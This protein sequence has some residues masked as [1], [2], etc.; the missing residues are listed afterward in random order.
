MEKVAVWGLGKEFS[1]WRTILESEELGANI[2]AWCD[3]DTEKSKVIANRTDPSSLPFLE[4]DII[5]TSCN[6]CS[7]IIKESERIGCRNARVMDFEA[8]VKANLKVHRKAVGNGIHMY[9]YCREIIER[10]DL[11]VSSIME[12]GANYGQDAEFLRLFWG[13]NQDHV[14]TFEANSSISKEIDQRYKFHNYNLAVSDYTGKATLNLVDMS[15]YNSGL[16]SVKNYSYTQNWIRDEVDCICMK[17]FMD[18]HKEI[19]TIDF[20]KVDV[21]GVD[22]EV[23]KGFG[24]YL[25]KVKVIQTEAENLIDY[26]GEHYLFSDIARLLMDFGF[27]LI[28][29]DLAR[30][31]SDSLWIKR[32]LLK[33]G[34]F[35]V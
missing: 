18:M 6:L 30:L 35:Q 7:E 14:F 29:Y 19:D 3:K 25:H 27:E 5:L 9:R 2:I 16:S 21:E 4:P 17:D 31:Q 15:G 12:I 32:E 10:T 8:F 26:E 11:K 20:L 13:T 33:K 34:K 24:D 22:Y 23:L 28:T 1:I